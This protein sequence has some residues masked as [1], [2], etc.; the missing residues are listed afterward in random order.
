MEKC[1]I[2][3]SKLELGLCNW[4]TKCINEEHSTYTSIID[5]IPLLTLLAKM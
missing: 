1:L 4:I 2:H 5:G 3:T